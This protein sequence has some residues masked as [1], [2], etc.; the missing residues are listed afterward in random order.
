MAYKTSE[1]CN[2]EVRNRE[3]NGYACQ[4]RLEMPL[5]SQIRD[6]LQD[7]SCNHG[8]NSV[9]PNQPTTLVTQ[10]QTGHLSRQFAFYGFSFPPRAIS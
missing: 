1:W 6:S 7:L 2:L 10:N 4:P 8:L 5:S 9:D 3:R